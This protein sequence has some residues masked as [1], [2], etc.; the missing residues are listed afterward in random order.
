VSSTARSF[1]S[2][3]FTFSIT[4]C[5]AVLAASGVG[6]TSEQQPDLEVFVREGCRHCAAAKEFLTDLKIRRPA[7]R[8]FLREVGADPA[9]LSR[10]AELASRFKIQPVGVPAFYVAGEL[11]VG[12]AEDTTRTKIIA[13]LDRAKADMPLPPPSDACRPTV[14]CDEP[15]P[16]PSRTADDRIEIPWLGPLSVRQIGLPAFTLLIGFVDG[17]NPCAMWVL[18]F[19]LSLLASLRDRA[20]MALIAGTFVLVSGLVYFAFMTAWLNAFLFVGLSRAVQI[21]LGVIAVLIGTVHIKDFF[22]FG[23]GLSFSIPESAKPGLY[24]RMRRILEAEHLPGT[25]LAVITLAVLVNL[26]ELLCTAGLPALYTQIL[27]LQQ[28]SWWKYYG[29]LG[30]YNLAYILDDGLMVAIAI[31]TLTRRRLQEGEGRW[32]KLV[33]GAVMAGLGVILLVKPDLLY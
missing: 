28:L 8:I 13:L 11:I 12:Y 27:T 33:S 16:S 3:L 6:A 24:T 25:L 22:A 1:H 17:F 32:L 9:A 4:L 21:A 31:V 20:K 29:Y 10:L 5:A 2:V 15:V 19:L 26:V 23:A 30:L 18:L 7:L 14:N